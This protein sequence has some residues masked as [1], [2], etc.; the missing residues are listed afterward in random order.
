M[1]ALAFELHTTEDLIAAVTLT[2]ESFFMVKVEVGQPQFKP[3]QVKLQ[4]LSGMMTIDQAEFYGFV[5]L[6]F[7][8]RFLYGVLQKLYGH[9]FSEINKSVSDSVGEL[10]NTV[11]GTFK[12]HLN[13]RGHSL[14]MS[15][16]T[17]HGPGAQALVLPLHDSVLIPF[18]SELGSFVVILNL[19]KK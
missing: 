7:E 18:S 8:D 15:I 9:A 12:Q 14:R 17:V 2:L 1:S 13:K 4:S 11:Y 5:L 19:N 16:P 3:L 6:S 10:T